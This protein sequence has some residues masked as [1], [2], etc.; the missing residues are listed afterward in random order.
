MKTKTQKID[1]RWGE[2]KKMSKSELTILLKRHK[3]VSNLKGLQKIDLM[4]DIIECEIG[5]SGYEH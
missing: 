5:W 4:N 1:S 3:R 2:L